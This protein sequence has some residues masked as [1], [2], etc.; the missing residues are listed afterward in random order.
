MQDLF[1]QVFT[2]KK[3]RLLTAYIDERQHDTWTLSDVIRV[4]AEVAEFS[5]P[6]EH[7][8]QGA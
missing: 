6:S 4:S 7:G 1:G 5:G 8:Y 3:V 2:T